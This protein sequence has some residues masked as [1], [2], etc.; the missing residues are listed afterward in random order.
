M[1]KVGDEVTTRGCWGTGPL[2]DVFVESM[3]ITTYPREKYGKDA[4]Q[5]PW[6]I[7]KQNRVIITLSSGRWA[8]AF[9]VA[10]LGK[11]PKVYHSK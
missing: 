2:Q 6:D 7:V 11:D 9:Q 1:L 4:P 3:E 8:Y 10:P 5:V